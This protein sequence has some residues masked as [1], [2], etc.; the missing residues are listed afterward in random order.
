MAQAFLK[1]VAPV[2]AAVSAGSS[3]AA[4]VHPMGCD[5]PGV[6]AYPGRKVEDWGIPDTSGK[7]IDEVRRIRDLLRARVEELAQCLRSASAEKARS[8]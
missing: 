5:D 1:R 3:P 4:A 7:P 8:R 6:C 2:H